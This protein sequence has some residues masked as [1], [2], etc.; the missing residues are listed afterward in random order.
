M[1]LFTATENTT[2]APT[3]SLIS[4]GW[5]T[6]IAR[7]TEIRVSRKGDNYLQVE[8]QL[9]DGDHSGARVW[10]N[11]N[12]WNSNPKAVE[13][14]EA[15]LSDFCRAIGIDAVQDSWSELCNRTL[16]AK[17]TVRPGDGDYGPR[18]DVAGFKKA[19]TP[20]PKL[21]QA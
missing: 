4:E 7:D 15:R 1:A 20:A 18:N 2:P 14:S 13:V 9:T 6:V 5:H 8:L 21:W 10:T 11:F 12:L 3:R 16:Q 17:I 19:D